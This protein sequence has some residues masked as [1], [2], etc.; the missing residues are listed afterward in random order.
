MA[1]FKGLLIGCI[2]ADVHKK[3]SW[4]ALNESYKIYILRV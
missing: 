2:D 3:Y 4:E 1:N